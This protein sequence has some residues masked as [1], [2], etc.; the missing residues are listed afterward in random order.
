MTPT[1]E[2]IRDARPLAAVLS[3][4]VMA[5]ATLIATTFCITIFRTEL[6]PKRT[7]PIRK[8]VGTH[9]RVF[10]LCLDLRASSFF[11]QFLQKPASSFLMP[12]NHQH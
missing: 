9:L 7:K 3:Q 5:R 2:E 8:E 1:V 4:R 6:A 12:P 11:F 10:Q